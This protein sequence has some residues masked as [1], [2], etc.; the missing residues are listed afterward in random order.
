MLEKSIKIIYKK[1]QK[2]VRGGP[3]PPAVPRGYPGEGPWDPWGV[4]PG[5]PRGADGGPM[6]GLKDPSARG[7]PMGPPGGSNKGQ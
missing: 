7:T 1:Y 5:D 2:F 6:G 4:S 3:G